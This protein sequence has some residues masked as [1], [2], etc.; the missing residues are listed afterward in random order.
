MRGHRTT[1]RRTTIFQMET[2]TQL[3]RI[4]TFSETNDGFRWEA[5][6]LKVYKEDGTQFKGITRQ[7]LFSGGGDQPCELRYFEMEPN[8][9]S[10][11]EKHVHTHAVLILRGSGRA[12]VGELVRKVSAFDLVYIP[13]L[14]WHQFRADRGE[15]LGFLC[16]VPCDRDRPIRPDEDDRKQLLS[17][18]V[19]ADFARL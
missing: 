12:L 17:D 11:F 13:S 3:E 1:A 5:V 14:T 15:S 7:T 18:P 8:G 10:T 6:P 2:N 16:Q 9:H 4:R 19:I